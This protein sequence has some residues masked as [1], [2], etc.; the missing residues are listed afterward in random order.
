MKRLAAI[1]GVLAGAVALT[2]APAN[3]QDAL[4]VA[5][6]KAFLGRLQAVSIRENREYCGYF[7]F[8]AEGNFVATKPQRGQQDSCEA[9]EPPADWDLFASY[10]THGAYFIDADTEVPSEGDMRADADEG[11]DGYISTPGGR[12]WFIDTSGRKVRAR[13]LCGRNCLLADSKFRD[14]AFPPPRRFYTLETITERD[15]Y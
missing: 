7:A 1:G 4:E 12:L 14:S 5:F 9:P 11:V 15:E 13:M 6:V 10:H 8:D 2:F 3:A